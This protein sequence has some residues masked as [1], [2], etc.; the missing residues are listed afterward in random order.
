MIPIDPSMIAGLASSAGG[1]AGG[2]GGAS[3][4]ASGALGG[5]GGSSGPGASA[6]AGLSLATSLVQGIQAQRQKKKADA[7]FPELVDPNQAAFLSELNQ[8]RRSIETGADFAGAM[9]KINA[10]TA[11]TQEAITRNTGGDVGGTIQ[12]LLQ[13]Q[14]SANSAK[15]AV[16]GQGQQ[17][18]LA[19][20]NMYGGLLNQISARRL[21]LQMQRSQQ[22]LG[23]WAKGQQ[24]TNQNLL[25]GLT[26]A[27][28]MGA[29]ALANQQPGAEVTAGAEGASPESLPMLSSL[30]PTGDAGGAGLGGGEL[31]GGADAGGLDLSALSGLGG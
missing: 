8:K 16:I 24:G 22:N 15:N 7:A 12:A 11:G 28:G 30:L 29:N 4:G 26:S 1:A 6:G 31:M 20:N 3:G 13:A 10:T 14:N 19:Y 25:A 5:L 23:E 2:A 27:A 18:Q 17:Q 9:D 21:Q